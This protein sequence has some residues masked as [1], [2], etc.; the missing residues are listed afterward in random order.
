MYIASWLG[1]FFVI[2]KIPP[3]I[4]VNLVISLGEVI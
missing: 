2:R 3:M 4:I 1:G